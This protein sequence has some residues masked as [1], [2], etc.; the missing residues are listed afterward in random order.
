MKMAAALAL[1][2]TVVVKGSEHTPLTIQR[3]VEILNEGGLPPGVLNLV[4]GRGPVTGESL[5]SHPGVDA[6]GFV[7]GTSTGKRIMASAAQNITKVGLELGGKSANIV[8]ESADL[9]AALD[10]SLLAILSG[11]G[12]QCLAGSR[13]LVQRKYCGRFHRE[14]RRPHVTGE[15]R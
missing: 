5:V 2:N 9:E 4:N 14:I 6:I 11:N 15:S 3:F 12:E 1:G 8:L 10:G 13:L 7:G